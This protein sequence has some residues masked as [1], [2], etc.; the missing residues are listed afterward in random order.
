MTK[1]SDKDI[2]KRIDN[3]LKKKEM[4]K[5][6]GA[7]FG[8]SSDLPPDIESEWLSN[9]EKFEEQFENAKQITVHKRLGEPTFKAESELSDIQL[10]N[11][12][13]RLY[14]IMD[15]EYISLDVLS[16]VDDRE[17]Y[18]FITEELFQQ[19]IDDMDLP[20]TWSCFI[21]EEF[22]PDAKL[23]IESSLDYFFRMTMAKMENIGGKGYDLLYIDTDN[24]MDTAGNKIPKKEIEKRINTFLKAYDSFEFI[25]QEITGIQINDKE[26]DA[27]AIMDV[28]YKAWVDK[29]KV[30]ENY[31]GKANFRL[32]PSEYGGWSIYSIDMPGWQV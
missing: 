10:A 7:Q 1:K 15:K 16:E 25:K 4:Q 23:D 19:E 21:Y 32:R 12:I 28:N 2:N 27:L 3:E 18:R 30:S 5:K 9:I 14:K 31:Q 20:G 11:E 24:Y 6:Y 17:I 13:E 29:G 22:H 26:N 8:G